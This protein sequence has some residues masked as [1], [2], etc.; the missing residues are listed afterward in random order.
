MFKPLT[1]MAAIVLVL[2]L[3]ACGDEEPTPG[4]GAS[5]A[6]A[7]GKDT[8]EGCLE[9]VKKLFAEATEAGDANAVDDKP[10]AECDDLSTEQQQ[11]AVS[12]A[13]ESSLGDLDKEL[14]KLDDATEEEIRDALNTPTP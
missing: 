14:E 2:G 9:A 3:A 12:K 1:A 4:A 11:E 8:P 5:N 7:D 10:P 6:A 13:L